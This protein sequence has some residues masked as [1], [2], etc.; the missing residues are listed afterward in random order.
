MKNLN[1]K[2][3]TYDFSKII[4][5]KKEWM[6]WH[7]THSLVFKKF[8]SF[9]PAQ[10]QLLELSY[11]Y[12]SDSQNKV[13]VFTAPPASGKTH[14]I[15]LIAHYFVNN[16]L[17]SCI[18]VPNGEL[19]QDFESE[20]KKIKKLSKKPEVLTFTK[21]L[22]NKTNYELAIVDEA[23]NLDS[24]FNINRNIVKTFSVKM[25]DYGFETIT[26]RF[27]KNKSFTVTQLTL[28][29][30][31]QILKIFMHNAN[32][33]KESA[34]IKK[35]LTSWLGFLISTK[36]GS[37]I[38]FISADPDSRQILSKG[39]L[40]LFSATPLDEKDLEFYCNIKSE[41]IDFFS[42]TPSKKPSKSN[43]KLYSISEKLDFSE[44]VEFC[45]T[46]FSNLKE[47]SL[48]L[49]NNSER[50][51]NWSKE[52]KKF[53]ASKRIYKIP[54]GITLEKRNEIFKKYDADRSGILI[55]SSSVFW[56]GITIKNLKSVFI[57]DE[58]F[59]EPNLL[60]IFFGRNCY[61]NRVIQRRIIQGLGR[62]GRNSSYKSIGI[63]LFP[64]NKINNIIKI[65]SDSLL[66][67]I[68]NEV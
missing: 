22:E 30:A 36:Y 38:K 3:S 55:T 24:A 18:V 26:E 59:P 53:L 66:E 4:K 37:K 15:S 5:T 19:K 13:S 32:T 40:M 28:E 7:E 10:K 46:I 43:T 47:K 64:Y 51:E 48:V 6:K 52:L 25:G 16:G 58:P 42:I 62:V 8:G 45:A 67:K 63:L 35:S 20:N 57:P 2:Y 56:E 41:N 44:K 17:T 12:F 14:I 33:R 49:V 61:Q 11:D 68:P 21:Y 34:K 27:L 65:D 1:R 60:D 9:L 29:Y 54:S 23:H 31:D 50:S 39:Q